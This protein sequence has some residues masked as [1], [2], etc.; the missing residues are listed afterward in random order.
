[1]AAR[2]GAESPVEIKIRESLFSS[3]S[4]SDQA[5]NNDP[6]YNDNDSSCGRGSD[7]CD[8]LLAKA[9]QWRSPQHRRDN[10]HEEQRQQRAGK[11]GVT[12]KTTA[13]SAAYIPASSL[14]AGCVGGRGRPW[15]SPFVQ[16][17][18]S[19]RRAIVAAPWTSPVAAH[20]LA[21]VQVR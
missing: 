19:L 12:R 21:A 1:M 16:K 9:P 11:S 20:N 7:D 4:S 6:N 17:P 14:A 18:R 13:T 5:W 10:I 15:R 2:T 3:A 8:Q